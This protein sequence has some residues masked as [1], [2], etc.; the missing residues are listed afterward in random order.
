MLSAFVWTFNCQ[1][2]TSPRFHTVCCKCAA[3]L[4]WCCSYLTLLFR[5]VHSTQL[6]NLC[7]YICLHFMHLC[8]WHFNAISIFMHF[9]AFLCILCISMLLAF[10]CI[11]AFVHFYAFLCMSMHFD[12]VNISTQLYAYL[13]C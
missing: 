5:D 3:M 9:Y 10:L 12:A 8:C 11:C 4:W 13:V 7:S 6:V 2:W 1:L